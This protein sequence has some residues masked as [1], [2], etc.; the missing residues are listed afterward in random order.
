MCE[1]PQATF[2]MLTVDDATAAT[3]TDHVRRRL[4]KAPQAT[5]AMLIA[6]STLRGC[7]LICHSYAHTVNTFQAVQLNQ[8]AARV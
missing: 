7:R 3:T 1:A 2:G 5:L 8:E 4:W 6:P